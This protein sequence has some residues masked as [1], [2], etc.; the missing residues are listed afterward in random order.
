[1]VVV[2]VLAFAICWCPIQVNENITCFFFVIFPHK[3]RISWFHYPAGV[4]IKPNMTKEI[5]NTE[6]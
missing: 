4:P 1:M 2:V 3:P 6:E 5:S